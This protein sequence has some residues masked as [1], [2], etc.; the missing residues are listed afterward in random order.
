ML[1]LL[2]ALRTVLPSFL[3]EV[4][5]RRYWQAYWR[6]ERALEQKLA[7]QAPSQ[8]ILGSERAVLTEAILWAYPFE[9]LLEVGCSFGQN[10]FTLSSLLPKVEFHGI[11]IDQ[12]RLEEGARLLREQG[13]KNVTLSEHSACDLS[14]FESRGFDV[15]VSCAMFLYLEPQQARKALAEMLRLASSRVILMEQH[16][17]FAS[18][19]RSEK[20]LREC[21]VQGYWLHD[22]AALAE[23]LLGERNSRSGTVRVER[24][25]APRWPAEKWKEHAHLIEIQL[26]PEL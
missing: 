13:V 11:D 2:L 24:I 7:P 12:G 8:A 25:P 3:L 4:C 23:D 20:V 17:D 14:S 22:Y 26:N 1:R 16:V 19:K 18:E 9:R 6:K 15:V 10:F 21:G 5:W